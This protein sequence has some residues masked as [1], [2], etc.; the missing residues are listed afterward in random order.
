MDIS[1]KHEDYKVLK[2][3]KEN[4]V[5]E[6]IEAELS[7]PEYMPEILRII[8]T[9]AK[10]EITSC[11]L[12]G[13]RVT[14]DGVC[15]IRI[16]YTAEDGCIYCFS[17]TRQFTRHCENSSFT[18]AI[19]VNADLDVSYVNCRATGTKRVEI[20]TG[21]LIKFNVFFAELQDVVSVENDCKIEQKCLSVKGLCLGCKKTRTFSMSDTVTLSVPSA[22]IVSQDAKAIVSEIRKINNKIMLKGEVVVNV[23]YV[24]SDNKALTEHVSHSIPLNQILE[25]EDLEEHFTGNVFVKV[26]SLDVLVKSEQNI[27]ATAFDLSL[28]LEADVTMWDEKE[29]SV[30]CDA[31]CI[32]SAITLEKK[33]YVFYESLSLLKDVCIFDNSFTVAGEGIESILDT[34]AEVNNVKTVYSNGELTV[35]GSLCVSLVVRDATNSLSN[36]NKIFDFTYKYKESL[37]AKNIS[38]EPRVNVLNVKCLVKNTN[39]IDVRAELDIAGT[40]L[41]KIYADA[42]VGLSLSEKAVNTSKMPVTIYFSEVENESLWEIARKY[43][44]TVSA[45]AEENGLSGDTTENVRILFIPSA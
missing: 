27:F 20:R 25:I 14:V 42:V 24:N 23:C 13:E 33:P 4:S 43:N 45:I 41:G 26:T 28:G 40:I 35:S 36:I 15:E 8:K 11:K 12:V 6:C 16:V 22:F 32:D 7:L 29:Y 19:D 31:Y 37:N 21:I 9:T 17:Q 38:C 44:T 10:P 1:L 18:D 39:T 34:F 2:A 3:N 5:E 30:I